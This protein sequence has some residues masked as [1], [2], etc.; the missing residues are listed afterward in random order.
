M[1]KLIT[2]LAAIAF[3]ATAVLPVA[4]AEP[5]EMVPIAVQPAEA[6]RPATVH[7]AKKAKKAKKIAKPK[8]KAKRAHKRHA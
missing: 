1:K 8:H 6:A 4:A 7:K 2:F 3:S 5:N